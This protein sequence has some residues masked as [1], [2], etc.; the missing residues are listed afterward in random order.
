M[1][2][3]I[4]TAFVVALALCVSSLVGRAQTAKTLD[5][6]IV[7]VEGGNAQL[8]VTPSGESMLIDTGNGGAAAV[9]DAERILA[10]VKE[11]GLK[12]IDHLIST[13]Y[14][15]DHMGGLPEVAKRI[16]IA[17]FID[18]GDNVNPG[19]NIDAI[20]K[21][22][23]EL[24]GK[25]KRTVPNPGDKIAI[26]GLDWRIVATGGKFL[27]TP[28]AG[29]GARNPYCANFQPRNPNPAD[30]LSVG[31]HVTFGRFRLLY[32]GDL[33]QNQEFELMCPVNPV[34]T[35]DLLVASCHGQLC[36]G[37]EALVHAV[38]PRVI[39]VNNSARKGGQPEAMKILFSSPRLENLWQIHF[40]ELS[41][42]EYSIPGV[43]IANRTDDASS[44]VAVEGI[45]APPPGQQGAGAPTHNGTAYYLKVSAQQDGTFTVTNSRNGFSK[46]YRPAAG[47]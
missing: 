8:Y 12:Q 22:Y 3:S 14:H 17:H 33:P 23:V 1:R 4:S 21:Q 27:K 38:Q 37:S 25:V 39:L 47:R 45:A 16:H 5:I 46:T 35:V 36:S 20:V 41:G 29:A 2:A 32:L 30:V 11:A 43:F 6:Y 42:Q 7:D 9:R 44:T 15:G 24:Y 31:S 10:V 19:A 40:S 34:G 28:L 13:H 18:P 26:N